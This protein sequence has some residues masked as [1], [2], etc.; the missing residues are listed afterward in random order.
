MVSLQT[1][2]KNGPGRNTDRKVLKSVFRFFPGPQKLFC[3]AVNGLSVK[4]FKV[5]YRKTTDRSFT[6]IEYILR[7]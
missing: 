1:F 6:T 7:L 4:N 3:L 5:C 2:W